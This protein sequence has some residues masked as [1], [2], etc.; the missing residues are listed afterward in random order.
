[1]RHEY[2]DRPSP[3]YADDGVLIGAAIILLTLIVGIS[4]YYVYSMW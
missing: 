2:E 1:M 3:F 4:V